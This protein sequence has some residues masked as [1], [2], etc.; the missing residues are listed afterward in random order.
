MTL[1]LQ[2]VA[3]FGMFFHVM[4]TSFYSYLCTIEIRTR[5]YEQGL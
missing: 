2:E 4:Q 1:N 3:N 5:L